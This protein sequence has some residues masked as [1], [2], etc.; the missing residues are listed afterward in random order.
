[1]YHDLVAPELFFRVKA[2]MALPF[3]MASARPASSEEREEAIAS[4]AAEEGK[5]SGKGSQLAVVSVGGSQESFGAA[6]EVGAPAR[7]GSALCSSLL[8]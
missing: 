6:K 5:A 3:L 1:M 4:K 8:T 2:K 7:L